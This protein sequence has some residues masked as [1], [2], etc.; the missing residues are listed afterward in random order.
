MALTDTQVRA[1]KP[2]AKPRK[3]ADEKG[4][5]LL[6]TTSGGK[7]WR[8]KYRFDGKEEVRT[9]SWTDYAAIPRYCR[10]STGLRPPSESLIRCWLYQRM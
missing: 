8:F 10:Y 1:L 9:F 5:F 2:D 3:H 7:L 6:V 4:L